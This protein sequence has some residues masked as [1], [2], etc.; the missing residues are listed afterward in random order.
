[1][2]PGRQPIVRPRFKRYHPYQAWR[3]PRH[4]TLRCP[5]LQERKATLRSPPS[6]KHDIT[7]QLIHPP[8][9][10]L[11]PPF[12]STS[13]LEPSISEERRSTHLQTQ[14]RATSRSTT[15]LLRRLRRHPHPRHRRKCPKNR[16]R[17][18]GMGKHCGRARRHCL[19]SHTTSL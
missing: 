8:H 3:D 16:Q 7:K 1:M 9:L 19:G 17:R 2:C 14:V 18:R 10:H 12:P 13:L 15:P 11:P 5:K 4:R 6:S